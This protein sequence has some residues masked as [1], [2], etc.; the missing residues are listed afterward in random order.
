MAIVKN[1]KFLNGAHV[2][3]HK[4]TND[5]QTLPLPVPER[6]TILMLQHMGAV[7]EPLV[8]K[9]DSVFVGQKIGES[10]EKMSVP[11]HASCSGTVQDIISYTTPQGISCPAVVIDTDKLQTMDPSIHKPEVQSKEEFIAALRESGLVGLGGAGFPTFMKLNYP[12]P[13][14]IQQLVINAAECE[15]YITADYR[16]CLENTENIVRGIQAIRKYFPVEVFIGV[17][18]NKPKAIEVLDQ[19]TRT[20][21]RV[22]VVE[23]KSLYPQGAE[24]SIVY[25]ATGKVIPQGSLPADCGVLVM[26]ISSVG[27]IGKYLEDGIPLINKR[28]TVDGDCVTHPANLLVPIGTS[29]QDVLDYCQVPQDY[30]KVLMGG[31]MMGIAVSDTALPVVKNNNALTV[32]SEKGAKLL[33]ETA[34]IRCGRCISICPLHLMPAKL[35]K[36][37]DNRNTELLQELCVDLCINCGCCSYICPAR[38][39]LAQKNQLAKSLLKQ[40]QVKERKT[41]E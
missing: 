2:P 20:L 23:L 16:E 31:P 27:F 26:N 3:H 17:E 13:E 36:A 19:A 1:K 18:S 5:S 25:A 30:A 4:N 28:L 8:K 21:D 35:E 10:S 6:V 14:K 7:C 22:T 9:G 40:R 11:V 32:F 12:H 34:C 38:R 39:H 24:K 15:P 41:N 29:I 37:Y 33:P